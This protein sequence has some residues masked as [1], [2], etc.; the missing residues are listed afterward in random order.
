M[1][2]FCTFAPLICFEAP[3][4]P[5]HYSPFWL[6]VTSALPLY[7]VSSL[8]FPWRV[9]AWV[10]C[11]HAWFISFNTC[12]PYKQWIFIFSFPLIDIS[13]GSKSWL[14][15]MLLQW[16]QKWDRWLTWWFHVNSLLFPSSVKNAIGNSMKLSLKLR[17][18]LDYMDSLTTFSFLINEPNMSF[19]FCILYN[20]FHQYF[21]LFIGETFSLPLLKFS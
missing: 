4:L 7:A 18:M 14:L 13:V 3:L 6:P 10:L 2:H 19:R 20:F 8:T 16:S 12:P 1:F 9:R 15:W 11:F 21:M 17:L 5:S